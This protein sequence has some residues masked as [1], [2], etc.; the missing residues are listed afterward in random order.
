VRSQ[1]Q[2]GN[3]A[4]ALL[5]IEISVAEFF[6]EIGEGHFFGL[7]GVGGEGF[8]DFFEEGGA[9]LDL[10]LEAGGVGPRA[11]LLGEVGGFEG[12]AVEAVA[13]FVDEDVEEFFEFLAGDGGR[14]VGVGGGKFS[15][16]G[17]FL[18]G[19]TRLTGWGGRFLTGGT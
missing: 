6:E 14:G 15:S 1:V 12:D 3:E 18:T 8:A 17:S 4:A 11:G 2:L 10:L 16:T 5:R 9:V 19:L 13:D 7:G